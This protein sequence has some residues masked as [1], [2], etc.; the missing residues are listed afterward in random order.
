MPQRRSA[1]TIG[2]TEWS[3]PGLSRRQA[4]GFDYRHGRDGARLRVIKG[5][6]AAFVRVAAATACG[7]VAALAPALGQEIRGPS[8]GTVPLTI[9]AINDFH[10][11]LKPPGG[12]IV[13]A[14]SAGGDMRVAAGGTERLATLVKQQRAKQRNSIF[15]A[16]GDLVGASPLLSALFHDEPTVEALSLMGL[17]LAAVGNHEFDKG[18]DELKRLQNGGCAPSSGVGGAITQFRVSCPLR[19]FTGATYH[20]LAASTVVRATG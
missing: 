2:Q 7:V 20:Y 8:E 11:N 17:D 10:G 12:G 16:A 3:P 4:P 13:I 19:P 14:D 6:S 9:L 1:G 18:Q 5:V 15:V